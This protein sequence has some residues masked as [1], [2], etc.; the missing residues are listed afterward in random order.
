MKNHRSG[1]IHYTV[2]IELSTSRLRVRFQ[3]HLLDNAL[4]IKYFAEPFLR[5][6]GFSM[7]GGNQQAN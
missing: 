4:L 5:V 7:Q 6:G 1:T 2:Q 3:R